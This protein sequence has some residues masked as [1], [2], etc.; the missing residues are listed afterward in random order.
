MRHTSIDFHSDK[1]KLDMP[2][3]MYRL[4]EDIYPDDMRY[5]LNL[6]QD[7]KFNIAGD[8]CCIFRMAAKDNNLDG[9][10]TN[11][12]YCTNKDLQPNLCIYN[13]K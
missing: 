13:S 10:K 12:N 8:K 7:C 9:T 11:N 2:L 4:R 3:Y 1:I 6:C 5:K